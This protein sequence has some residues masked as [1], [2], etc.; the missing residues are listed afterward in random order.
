MFDTN[1]FPELSLFIK[2][3]V[4]CFEKWNIL[5]HYS[6]QPRA[7]ENVFSLTQMTGRPEGSIKRA[8]D[9]LLMQGILYTGQDGGED[10]YLSTE[11]APIFEKL[12]Q[13]LDDKSARLRLLMVA[14]ETI[15]TRGITCKGDK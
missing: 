3:T 5:M 14:V 4:D 13:G 8:V 11:K 15:R 7:Q 6:R 10:L 9:D 12:K 1:D 2:D